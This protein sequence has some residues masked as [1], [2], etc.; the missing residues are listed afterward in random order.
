MPTPS[1]IRQRRS[2][3]QRGVATPFTCVFC[4]A[5]G[6]DVPRSD[7]DRKLCAACAQ[8]LTDAGLARCRGCSTLTTNARSCTDCNRARWQGRL[9][10]GRRS[11]Q[12]KERPNV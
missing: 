4:Q 8:T 12:A 9:G 11:H 7:A 10:T 2:R 3:E 6:P 1:A 5:S